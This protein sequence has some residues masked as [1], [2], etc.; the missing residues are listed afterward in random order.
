ML[1]MDAKEKSQRI[2]KEAYSKRRQQ[3]VAALEPDIRLVYKMTP[4]IK[5]H[6]TI[7]L[8]KHTTI[9]YY[10]VHKSFL[11]LLFSKRIVYNFSK[12][13]KVYQKIPL[14]WSLTTLISTTVIV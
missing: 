4:P 6:F 1:F 13:I 11:S 9:N 10:L 2:Y 8:V 7:F 3:V 14:P 5:S 12:R